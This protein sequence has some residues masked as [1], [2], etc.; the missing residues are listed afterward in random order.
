MT[1][2]EMIHKTL[3]RTRFEKSREDL[4]NKQIR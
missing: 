4:Y 2:V 1:F 3:L